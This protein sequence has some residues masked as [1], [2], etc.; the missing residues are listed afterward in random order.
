MLI[1]GGCCHD[2]E[3]Q[4]VILSKEISARARVEWTI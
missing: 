4:K 2:Y 1:T 3:R